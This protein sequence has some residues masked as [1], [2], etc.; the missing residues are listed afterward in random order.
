MTAIKPGASPKNTWSQRAL[1]LRG[2]RLV[3]L[4]LSRSSLVKRINLLFLVNKSI[5]CSEDAGE[6]RKGRASGGGRMWGPTRSAMISA[7]LEAIMFPYLS[8]EGFQLVT[9]VWIR[10]WT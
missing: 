6:D 5:Y 10:R 8:G 7:H 9:F 4:F 2:S 1:D 3:Q